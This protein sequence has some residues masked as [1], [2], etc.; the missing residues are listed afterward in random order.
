MLVLHAHW[1]APRRPEET[2]RVLFWAEDS[3]CAQPAMHYGRL[4]LKPRPKAHPYQTPIN[5][6]KGILRQPDAAQDHIML[7]L[8][9]TRSGPVPSPRLEH[10]WTLDWETPA[11]L[12][13]WIA[14]GL[15]FSPQEALPLLLDLPM[16]ERRNRGVIAG[17]D[18]RYWRIATTL[19]L[20]AL[21]AQKTVPVINPGRGG[22]QARW[23]AVLDSPRDSQ[24]LA[25]MEKNMP[26]VCRAEWRDP[27][28]HQP[29]RGRGKYPPNNS[30][31]NGGAQNGDATQW[32]APNP[33]T[34]RGLLTSFLNNL[35]DS[36]ARQ[37]GAEHI[38]TTEKRP[39]APTEARPGTY[40]ARY[41]MEHSPRPEAGNGNVRPFPSLE[42][43]PAYNW[44]T[45]LFRGDSTIRGS[46]AQVQ[47]LDSGFRAWI[48]NLHLAGDAT[49]RI[50]FRL[51][52]PE[53]PVIDASYT[54][55]EH[56]KRD[57]QLH[58]LLQARDD[59]SLLVPADTG[60]EN[61]RQR[62]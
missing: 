2:G 50:T 45:A 58:Y 47:A 18:G 35:C 21:A 32:G 8:P 17:E 52:A 49:F 28:N 20:E 22:F 19:V 43:H 40:E 53:N 30:P 59:P 44:L 9:S 48:R 36:L 15:S 56:P 42:N 33:P 39:L 54:G 7:S 37:W 13:P 51:E 11:F 12:A 27:N 26:P 31:S 60:V 38:R 5:T 62:R 14:S 25:F 61:H 6:L 46:A 24:R 23:L 41:E 57:W 1:S 3:N 16:L 34:P 29:P 10:N 55:A 4:S